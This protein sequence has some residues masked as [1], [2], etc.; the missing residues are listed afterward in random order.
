MAEDVQKSGGVFALAADRLFDGE[1]ILLNHAAMVAGGVVTQILP[2]HSVP[3]D[4]PLMSEPQTTMI[5]G[6]IDVH[7]HFMRWQGPIFLAFGVTAI[8]DAGNDLDWILAQR[9]KAH[10]NR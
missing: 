10:E 1:R 4:I 5:P 9:K 3:A 8:R 2:R 7:T 6:L